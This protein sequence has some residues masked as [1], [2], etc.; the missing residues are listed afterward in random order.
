ME[1]TRADRTDVDRGP[2]IV[3]HR[4]PFA[5][6]NTVRQEDARDHVD[7]YVVAAP[8]TDSHSDGPDLSAEAPDGPLGTWDPRRRL[9]SRHA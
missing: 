8:T 1:K 4:R 6:R 2:C 3:D 7:K 5:A 9:H